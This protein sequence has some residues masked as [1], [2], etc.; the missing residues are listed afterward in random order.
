[1][2]QRWETKTRYYVIH[3]QKDLFGTTTLR[4]V[5]GGIGTLRGGQRIECMEPGQVEAR[6][7]QLTRHR[8]RRGYVQVQ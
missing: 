8:R 5:W 2:Y 4:R 7:D 3:V 1:M 6:I